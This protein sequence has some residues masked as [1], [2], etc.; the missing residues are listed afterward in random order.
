M[1]AIFLLLLLAN[2]AFFAWARYYVQPD[3][4]T[5]P[6]PLARQIDPQKLP[7]VSPAPAR[8]TAAGAA[9][10]AAAP[11]AASADC[12]EWGS[13]GLTDLPAARR[14]LAPLAL[15]TRLSER[16]VQE[17][18]NWWVYIPPQED[19]QGAQRKA[20]ELKA[21]GVDEFVMMQDPGSY[22]WSISLGV[23]RSEAAAQ[24]R[25][26]QLK[27]KGVRSAQVGA[28]V[29]QI[30]KV[31]LQVR[32]ANAALRARLREVAQSIEGSELRDCK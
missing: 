12:I 14:L 24:V 2:L 32:D 26:V 19:R 20:A 11:A 31:W 21:L 27:S 8:G 25:L 4:G 6:Q 9:P 23:F 17:T 22:Q 13:F 1:R 15:G 28:R 3:A 30:S 7:I 18:A 10:A 5:D 16:Q 29:S